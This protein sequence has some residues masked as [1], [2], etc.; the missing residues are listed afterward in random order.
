MLYC[1]IFITTTRCE[2]NG[3]Y[4]WQKGLSS[5]ETL[6]LHFPP[7]S[8]QQVMSPGLM[9]QKEIDNH[10]GYQF[11]MFGYEG[12]FWTNVFAQF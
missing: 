9:V 7:V 1:C 4:I 6:F 5:A 11:Q 2:I 8:I 3:K 12:L 10:T